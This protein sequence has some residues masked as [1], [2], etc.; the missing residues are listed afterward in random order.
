MEA[1]ISDLVKRFERGALSRRQLV[2]GLTML[3]AGGAVAEAQVPGGG[4]FSPRAGLNR[5]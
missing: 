4:A 2:Q 3:A 1:M 5:C